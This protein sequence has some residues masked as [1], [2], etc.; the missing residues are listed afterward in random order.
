VPTPTDGNR[1]LLTVIGFMRAAPASARNW[2]R[3]SRLWSSRPSRRTGTSTT[4]CTRAWTTPD[5]FAFY[6]NW[7]AGEKLDA[8]LAAPHLVD[9]AAR[10]GDLLDDA[11]LSINR[12]RRIAW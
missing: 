3:R 6:E 11:G 5:F 7:V 8:H 12:V 1:E 4:T 2:R 9:F 10:I